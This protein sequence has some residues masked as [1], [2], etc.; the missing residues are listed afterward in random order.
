M[1]HDKRKESEE[2]ERRSTNIILTQVIEDATTTPQTDS[3]VV[4]DI[5]KVT[6]ANFDPK[7][8][9][10]VRRLGKVSTLPD[11]ALKTG[12]VLV[13]LDSAESSRAVIAN[14]RALRDSRYKQ[15]FIQ[16]DYTAGVQILLRDLRAARK[17][18]NDKLKNSDEK[19]RHFETDESGILWCWGIRSFALCK[20]D[21]ATGRSMSQRTVRG[22]SGNSGTPSV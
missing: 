22:A 19:G 6:N 14:A 3:S 15:V 2:Q 10:Q 4:L 8:V 18:Q 1:V 16:K 13:V 5:L 9:K 17:S 20:I 11:G 12:P 7:C 21:L